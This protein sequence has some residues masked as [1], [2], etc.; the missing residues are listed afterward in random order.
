[1]LSHS[2]K[3]KRPN[4]LYDKRTGLKHS[5]FRYMF[6]YEGFHVL[7]VSSNHLDLSKISGTVICKYASCTRH[8]KREGGHSSI[9]PLTTTG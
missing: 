7:Y 3:M 1:M 4:E 9:A 8:C 6:H 2:N 5:A